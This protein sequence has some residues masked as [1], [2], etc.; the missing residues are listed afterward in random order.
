M[1]DPDGREISPLHTFSPVPIFTSTARAGEVLPT[2]AENMTA[3]E[4]KTFKS[5]RAL[6]IAGSAPALVTW[7]V[8][9]YPCLSG[10]YSGV[11]PA[12]PLLLGAAGIICGNRL[13]SILTPV[14]VAAGRFAPGMATEIC[15]SLSPMD[16][17]VFSGYSLGIVGAFL[18]DRDMRAS[19]KDPDT[20]LIDPTIARSVKWTASISGLAFSLL[21][22]YFSLT[23]TG[24]FSL[25]NLLD[26]ALVALLSLFTLKGQL[27]AA[28]SQLGLL[29]VS[30]ALSWMS[31]P[32]EGEML[33]F[34][35]LL[36]FQI[37]VLG[38]V[39]V[40]VAKRGSSAGGLP[41]SS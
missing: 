26:A 23:G 41:Q 28:A 12:I 35:P 8:L 32:G 27:W 5:Y 38:I 33:G 30:I 21:I 29:L 20:R 36:L 40:I 14:Y 13:A 39:G 10:N 6:L 4:N 9:S 17:I 18:R 25:F 22:S 37:Y 3:N 16:A 7:V 19:S 34:I 2:V 24:P 15:P 31:S 1:K 11:V